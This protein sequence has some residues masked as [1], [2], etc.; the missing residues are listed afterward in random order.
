M[1]KHILVTGGTSG[2]GLALCKL[3]IRDHGCHVYLGSIDQRNGAIAL[4][5][6]L[7]EVPNKYNQIE[8]IQINVLD[9]QSCASAA[10]T[11][12]DKG[13]KL[14]ALVNNAGIMYAEPN[15]VINTNFKGD[16]YVPK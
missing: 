2:I 5:T 10:K 8:V 9:D 6:I 7:Q 14:Y 16:I 15:V 3:L 12:Q 1:L 13:V 4:K 11:L